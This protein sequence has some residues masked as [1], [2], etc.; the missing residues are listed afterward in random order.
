MM[1]DDGLP[2]VA[3]F[4]SC[5]ACF[6]GDVPT[7]I[8]FEGEAEWILAGLCV[9]GLPEDQAYATL[10]HWLETEQGWTGGAGTV[11][12]GTLRFSCVCCAEC[13]APTFPVGLPEHAPVI[14]QPDSQGGA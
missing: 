2:L 1:A 5:I 12:T 10:R 6:K 7:V 13:A 3:P 14:G 4:E 9:L 11:P 8:A